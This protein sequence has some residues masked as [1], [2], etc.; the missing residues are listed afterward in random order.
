MK[1][2]IDLKDIITIAMFIV[3][4]IT[5]GIFTFIEQFKKK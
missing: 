5:I 3:I 1:V 4:A 2:F